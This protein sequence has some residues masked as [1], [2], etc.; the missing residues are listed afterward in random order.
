MRKNVFCFGCSFTNGIHFA[1]KDW[2]ASYPYQLSLLMPDVD[3]YNLG[4]SG[5]NNILNDM[6][7]KKALE[8]YSVDFSI[9]QFTFPNRFYISLSDSSEKIGI[10]YGVKQLSDNYYLLSKEYIAEYFN[11]FTPSYLKSNVQ[12]IKQLY[13]LLPKRQIAHINETAYLS[14]LY[15]LKDLHHYTW[16]WNED[17]LGTNVV[18][19]SLKLEKFD[20]GTGHLTQKGNRVLAGYLKGEIA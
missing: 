11:I 10:R 7:I 3:V 5:G 9:V 17:T 18:P 1:Q 14:T 13:K 12:R 6:I 19:N 4:V 20:D 15:R 2:R 16:S 8:E